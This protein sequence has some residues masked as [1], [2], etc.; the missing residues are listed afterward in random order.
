[1]KCPTC[2]KGKKIF[3]KT[4]AAYCESCNTA[5]LNGFA[6]RIHENNPG[7][8]MHNNEIWRAPEGTP[9][10]WSQNGYVQKPAIRV[11]TS[12]IEYLSQTTWHAKDFDALKKLT[13]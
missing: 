4:G 11:G 9:L 8:W 3:G 6:V 12:E 5:Y 7:H 13:S 1:M 10:P 2:K